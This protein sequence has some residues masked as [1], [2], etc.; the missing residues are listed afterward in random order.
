MLVNCEYLHRSECCLFSTILCLMVGLYLL[1]YERLVK[2]IDKR[3]SQSKQPC[4]LCELMALQ[5]QIVKRVFV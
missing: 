5:I 1:V 2:L 3:R 4:G